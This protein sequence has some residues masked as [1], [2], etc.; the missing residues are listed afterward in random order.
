MSGEN[1]V[2]MANRIGDFFESMPDRPEALEGIAI[3]IRKFWAPSMRS[4]L[5]KDIDSGAAG[6]LKPIVSEA[7]ALHRTS[8][9]PA[10]AA[11]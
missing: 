1:L 11:S 3:H 4:A 6:E 10:S 2:R 8:L 9:Q 7:I 5:L